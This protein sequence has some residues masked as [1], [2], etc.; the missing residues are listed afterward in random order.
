MENRLSNYLLFFGDHYPKIVADFV[1]VLQT[2]LPGEPRIVKRYWR[3]ET[4]LSRT[5]AASTDILTLI[6]AWVFQDTAE[7]AA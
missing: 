3:I 5:H 1:A 4:L 2:S 6:C 7:A